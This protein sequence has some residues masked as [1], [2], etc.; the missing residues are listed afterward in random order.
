MFFEIFSK[1]SIDLW[2]LAITICKLAMDLLV[3]DRPE[4][5]QASQIEPR[6]RIEFE[7][8]LAGRVER[9]GHA[10]FRMASARAAS[11]IWKCSQ[12]GTKWSDGATRGSVIPK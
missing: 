2:K 10:S 3:L 11:V 5:R 9:L 6:G 4:V 12:T 1:F 8:E 7:P